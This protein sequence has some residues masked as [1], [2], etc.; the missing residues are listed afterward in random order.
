MAGG[1]GFD[2]AAEDVGNIVHLEH[3]NTR[4]PDQRLAT[5]FYISGLGLTRDPHFMT[6]TDN[7]WVNVGRCQFH[8]PTGTPQLLR[9]T[10]GLVIPDRA[11]LLRR[12]AAVSEDLAGTRFDV[13]EAE[14]HVFVTSPWGNRIRIHEPAASFGPMRL[15]MPYVALDVPPGAAEPIARFYRE[16]FGVK[17][18]V[19]QD[20][21]AARAIVPAGIGQNLVFEETTRTIPAFDGHHIAIYIADFSTPYRRLSERGLITEESDQH[22]WRFKDIIDPENGDVVFSLEHEVRSLH[23]PFFDRSLVNRDPS[24]TIRNYT[25]GN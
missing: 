7:M 21:G 18:R 2:R 12:L 3:V 6:G 9:G 16:V 1:A 25:R 19:E 11:A 23:H 17:A 5:L 4:V 13:I 8:L 20:N 15:G 10:T 22:Q 14:D 24:V